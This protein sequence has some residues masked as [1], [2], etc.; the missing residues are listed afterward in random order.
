MIAVFVRFQFDDGVDRAAVTAIA[1]RAKQQ[2]EGLPGLRSKAFTVDEAG[3]EAVNVYLWDS[4]EAA[5]AFFSDEMVERIAGLYGER[6]TIRY[7]AV[8]VLV[9]NAEH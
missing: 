8:A 9:D 7:A 5:R 1:E 3:G 2:F 6:P 4:E